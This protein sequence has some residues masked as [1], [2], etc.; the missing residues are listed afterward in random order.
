MLYRINIRLK[1]PNAR[2]YDW[3]SFF[4]EVDTNKPE[5]MEEK[6]NYLFRRVKSTIKD[7]HDSEQLQGS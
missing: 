6:I 4:I 3:D 5:E 1:E 7:R 2:Q